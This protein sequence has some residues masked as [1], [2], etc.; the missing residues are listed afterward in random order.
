MTKETEAFIADAIFF[1]NNFLAA[2]G[3]GDLSAALKLS[4][5]CFKINLVTRTQS[6]TAFNSFV[7]WFHHQSQDT[8]DVIGGGCV[9]KPT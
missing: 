3:I 5:Q 9:H 8:A 1:V 2:D 6:L 4:I 7:L